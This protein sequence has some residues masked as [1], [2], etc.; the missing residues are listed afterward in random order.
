MGSVAIIV[1]GTICAPSPTS[2]VS[3][4]NYEKNKTPQRWG[5]LFLSAAATTVEA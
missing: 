3:Y 4:P 5:V 1:V 2:N